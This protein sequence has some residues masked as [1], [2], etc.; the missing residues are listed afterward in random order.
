MAKRLARLTDQGGPITDMATDEYTSFAVSPADRCAG[1]LLVRPAGASAH[2]ATG[3]MR[4]IRTRDG[5]V[6]RDL[7]DPG[8]RILP[9]GWDDSVLRFERDA[10]RGDEVATRQPARL[11]IE[12]EPGLRAVERHRHVGGDDRGRAR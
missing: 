8:R 1:P 12:R 3:P 6:P 5:L 11:A 4:G 9:V 7:G 2:A 10:D